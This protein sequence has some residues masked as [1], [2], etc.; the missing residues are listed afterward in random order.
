MFPPPN[1]L[2]AQEITAFPKIMIRKWNL[3]AISNYAIENLGKQKQLPKSDT[4]DIKK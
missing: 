4:T 3:E 2:T 1:G